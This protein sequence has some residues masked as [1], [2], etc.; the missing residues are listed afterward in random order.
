MLLWF[1]YDTS[2]YTDGSPLIS[3]KYWA[4]KLYGHAPVEDFDTDVF[5]K[6]L[7]EYLQDY[8]TEADCARIVNACYEDVYDYESAVQF[9][10]NWLDELSMDDFRYTTY[11]MRWLLTCYAITTTVNEWN[12]YAGN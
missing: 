11:K 2:L 8:S 1:G 9:L 10:E 5:A 4:E 7:A 3:P 12:T 6:D